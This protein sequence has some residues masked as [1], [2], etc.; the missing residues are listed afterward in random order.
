MKKTPHPKRVQGLKLILKCKK[1][2]TDGGARLI[3]D[4][5]SQSGS[6]VK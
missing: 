6:G 1:P 4:L 2:R 5:L 3:F